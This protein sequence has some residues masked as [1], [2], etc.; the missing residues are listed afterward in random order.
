MV[1]NVRNNDGGGFCR[2]WTMLLLLAAALFFIFQF[3]ECH[4]T[5]KTPILQFFPTKSLFL[6]VRKRTFIC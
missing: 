6:F 3:S 2:C 5:L 1:Q 4:A